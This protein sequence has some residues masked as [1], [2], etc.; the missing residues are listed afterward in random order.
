VG[1]WGAAN[2]GSSCSLTWAVDGR[3]VRCSIISSCLL[4][5]FESTPGNE[6]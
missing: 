5:E 4:R 3:I 1:D 2:C 6:F